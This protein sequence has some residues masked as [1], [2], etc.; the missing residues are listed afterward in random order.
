MKPKTEEEILREKEYENG[1]KV[2][3]PKSGMVVTVHSLEEEIQKIKEDR[4]G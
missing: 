3:L 2:T 4:E 1:K